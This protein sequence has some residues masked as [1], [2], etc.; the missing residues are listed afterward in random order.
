M[1]SFGLPVPG[2]PQVSSPISSP[3]VPFAPVHKESTFLNISIPA[4]LMAHYEQ[5]SNPTFHGRL[6]KDWPEDPQQLHSGGWERT[7]S[8]IAKIETLTGGR[9]DIQLLDLCCGEGSTAKYVAEHKPWKVYG[10]DISETA[11]AVAKGSTD[12]VEFV[13]EDATKMS[14]EE[15][16]FD[17]IIGQDPDVFAHEPRLNCM[18]ECFRVLKK[19]GFLL[20]HHHWIP[21]RNWDKG[22]LKKYCKESGAQELANA[23]AYQADL[24]KA[25]F[26]VEEVDDIHELAKSHLTTMLKTMKERVAKEGGKVQPWLEV[27]VQYI[28]N[29]HKFGAQFVA[30]KR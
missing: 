2:A 22:V 15:G 28:E 30:Y 7:K 8:Q 11:I 5:Y 14:Y 27:T 4:N 16:S 25:G 20:F 26:S 13:C 6:K 19:G 29:G 18:Q 24:V 3:H 10:V 1:P 17:V 9:S 12:K 21:G 23:D